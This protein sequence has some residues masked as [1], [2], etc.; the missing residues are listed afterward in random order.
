MSFA[1]P[2]AVRDAVASGFGGRRLLVVGDLMLDRYLWGEVQRISPEAPVPVLRLRRESEVAGGAANVA[3]NLAALGLRVELAGVTGQDGERERLLALLAEA[4]IETGAVLATSERGTSTKTRAI[5]NHQQMLRIDAEET[6]PLSAALEDAL[7]AAIRQR[8]GDVD[9]LLLSD[10]AKGVLSGGLCQ[11]LIAA[12]RK[13]GKPVWIDPKGRDFD[14]YRGASLLTPN[15]AE[16]AEVLGLT[17]GNVDALLDGAAQLRESLTLDALV[18]TLGEHGMALI[19]PDGRRQLPARAR[20]VFDVSGAGDTAIAVLAAAVIVG[21]PLSDA[22]ALANLGAGVVVGRIGT[23]QLSAAEL[24]AAMED[25]YSATQQAKI[26]TLGALLERLHQWR[27]QGERIVFTNGCFDLLH[28]GHVSYLEQ[29]RQHGRRLIVG[30]NSD[31]SVRALK[32][33]QRPMM[34]EADRARVL[35]AL[36]AVDAVVLFGE[37]TPLELI[38]AI[39]P[40]VLVKGADY[41]PEQVVGADEVQRHGGQL[42]LIPLLPDRSTSDLVARLHP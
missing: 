35:A 40:D 27:D 23:A 6:A 3:R 15:R 32:G 22:V 19:Q 36:A 7:F 9:G 42:V 14:R 16:L 25:A 39:R 28:A 41:R 2:A 10:Y 1:D 4:G 11:R 31:D 20:E 38:R 17:S 33:P 12:A 24:L 18:V 37:E 29:A 34:P 13:L 26:L 30:L 5:G 8:L 21:L